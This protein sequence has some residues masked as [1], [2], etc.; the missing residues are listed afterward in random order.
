M[1]QSFYNG[2]SGMLSFS[3][4]LDTVSNN[5]ANMNTPGYKGKDSFYQS[6]GGGGNGYGA[7]IGS[8][9]HRMSTGDIKST[10]NDTDLAITG[11]GLFVL[12][13]DGKLVYSKAGQFAF[14][15][16]GVLIDK[17]TGAKVMALTE[18]GDLKQISIEE[19]S[20]LPPKTTTEVEFKGNLSSD[21]TSH[22]ASGFTVFNTLGAETKLTF[23]FTDNSEETTGSWLVTVVDQD[24]NEVGNGEIRFDS[25]GLLVTD[26]NQFNIQIDNGSGDNDTINIK[27]G[28]TG[29]LE[30]TT[31]VSGGST[32]SLKANSQDGY[33]LTSLTSALFDSSGELQLTYANGEERT[34]DKI[35]LAS[36]KDVSA[37]KSEQ[38]SLFKATSN[39]TRELSY[40]G[41][42]SFGQIASKSL[43]LSNV[44]LS[45]EFADMIVIQNGYQASSRILN[46]SNQLLETLFENTRGR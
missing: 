17:A 41:E 43:E 23:D 39:K 29:S 24:G 2:L 25:S 20:S 45:S 26:Y 38:G 42:G 11:D 10:G 15:G 27:F 12:E 21:A 34:G 22:Q 1:S 40:A 7:Q 31:S 46:V 8:E 14:N 13:L 9:A 4:N 36:F 33:G 30:G 35:A 18:G 16:D 5:I 37:L 19:H 32:S 6:L 3:Q 44:D 28:E